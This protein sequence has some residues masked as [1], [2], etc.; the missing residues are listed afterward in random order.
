MASSVATG[1]RW[2]GR[3]R[4]HRRGT[5]GSLFFPASG[6]SADPCFER[7]SA[8]PQCECGRAILLHEWHGPENNSRLPQIRVLFLRPPAAVKK[9]GGRDP[10][11]AGSQ[12]LPHRKPSEPG[13]T[14]S[15]AVACA[16]AMMRARSACA[17]ATVSVA[18]KSVFVAAKAS[19]GDRSSV[20]FA[21]AASGAFVA[22]SLPSSR[23]I[24]IPVR[25]RAAIVSVDTMPISSATGNRSRG[26]RIAL[27]GYALLPL[28]DAFGVKS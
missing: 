28:F 13:A 14:I 19:A 2:Q 26:A 10:L 3:V 22:L 27:T 5:M 21:G 12:P 1:P 15:R 9:G 7:T 24:K 18:A 6:A 20:R 17:M 25:S 23:A 11:L 16:S 8:G 4:G